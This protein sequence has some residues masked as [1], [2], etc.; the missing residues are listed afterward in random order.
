MS[1]TV[2]IQVNVMRARFIDSRS[3]VVFLEQQKCME[4]VLFGEKFVRCLDVLGVHNWHACI[5]LSTFER[6][7]VYMYELYKK[8]SL[9]SPY[10]HYLLCSLM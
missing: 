1:V 7:S 6:V 10:I 2:K 5:Y 3:F 4:G 9:H 8:K